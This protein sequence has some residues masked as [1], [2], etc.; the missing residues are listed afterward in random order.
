MD[1]FSL[2]APYESYGLY[3]D[4]IDGLIG[5]TPDAIL[6]MMPMQ[7]VS[8]GQN[9]SDESEQEEVSES[10]SAVVDWEDV[11][12]T[13]SESESAVVSE[14]EETSEEEEISEQEETTEEETSEKEETSEEEEISEKEETTEEETSEKEETTEESEEEPAQ[15]SPAV[16]VQMKALRDE[17]KNLK[18]LISQLKVE[19]ATSG[20][21]R[22]GLCAEVAG[23]ATAAGHS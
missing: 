14:K 18:F 19:S 2:T 11:V 17:N 16:S 1:S 6:N 8:T 21:T 4:D 9:E 7:P 15:V 3:N 22:G 20:A 10:E 23:H 13:G 12:S 5:L